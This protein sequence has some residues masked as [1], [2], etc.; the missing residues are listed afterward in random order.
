MA[1]EVLLADREGARGLADI[2]FRRTVIGLGPD[3]GRGAVAAVAAVAAQR[4][5]WSDERVVRESE[6]V[7]AEVARMRPRSAAPASPHH[8]GEPR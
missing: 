5:G 7:A 1:A 6:A 3:A 4:L 8:E 2:L